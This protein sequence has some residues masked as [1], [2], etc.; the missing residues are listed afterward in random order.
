[1]RRV[2]GGLC[3]AKERAMP[4]RSCRVVGMWVTAQR[5]SKLC[6]S[7][8]SCPHPFARCWGSFSVVRVLFEEV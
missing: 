5:L 6:V 2:G 8:A 1:V 7:R 3:L 4:G